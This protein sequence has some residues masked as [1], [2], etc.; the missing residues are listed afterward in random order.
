MGS[1]QQITTGSELKLDDS[2]GVYIIVVG[3][4]TNTPYIGSK[5]NHKLR[6]V[7]NDVIA[8]EFSTDNIF[9]IYTDGSIV[10][11]SAIYNDANDNL[12]LL[13]NANNDVIVLGRHPR[14]ANGSTTYQES[15]IQSGWGFIIGDATNQLDA[16]VTFPIAYSSDNVRVIISSCGLRAGSAPADEGDFTTEV[17]EVLATVDNVT[18]TGFAVNLFHTIAASTFSVANRYGFN[19]ISI[20]PVV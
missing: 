9:R 16:A 7:T 5:S 20:G 8:A 4:D 14:N 17:P 10:N 6:I 15:H 11:T 18:A 3:A 1:I 19:W 13:T 2:T 12:R